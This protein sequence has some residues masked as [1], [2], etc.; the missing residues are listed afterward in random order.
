MTLEFLHKYPISEPAK[1][2]VVGTFLPWFQLALQLTPFCL[3]EPSEGVI[4]Y[5]KGHTQSFFFV[6]SAGICP[7]HYRLLFQLY[8]LATLRESPW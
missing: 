3:I 6:L 2:I 8:L 7:L 1:V 4:V 5:S